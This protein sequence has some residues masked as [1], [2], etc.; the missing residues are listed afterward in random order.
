MAKETDEIVS[1]LRALKMLM[2][3]QLLRQGARQGQIAAMLGVSERTVGRMLP[4]GVG[5]NAQ[6]GGAD[7]VP[8]GVE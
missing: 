6:K 5:K 4:K 2:I 1:E 3:L 7:I 8:D